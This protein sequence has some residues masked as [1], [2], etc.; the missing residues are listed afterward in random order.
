MIL[1]YQATY[2]RAQKCQIRPNLL[3]LFPLPLPQIFSA[4]GR[5]WYNIYSH[6]WPI[7]SRCSVRPDCKATYGCIW[8]LSLC[9]HDELLVVRLIFLL[10]VSVH[11]CLQPSASITHTFD[12]HMHRAGVP[13]LERGPNHGGPAPLTLASRCGLCGSALSP[14]RVYARRGGRPQDDGIS[15]VRPQPLALCHFGQRAP[16]CR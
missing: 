5:F 11:T 13:R 14:G 12:N 8:L 2:T 3:G 10:S 4:T 6:L 1:I 15:S 16:R 9:Y 7:M